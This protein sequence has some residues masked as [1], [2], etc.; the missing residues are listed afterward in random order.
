M[1]LPV[2]LGPARVCWNCD[3]LV[4]VTTKVAIP[5]RS[6]QLAHFSLCAACYTT[7]YCQLV[8]SLEGIQPVGS[9]NGHD[10]CRT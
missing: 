7:V 3:R 6:G 8:H 5:V 4:S 10:S 9:E 2:Y 1:S